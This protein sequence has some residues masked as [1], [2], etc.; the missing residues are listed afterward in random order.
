MVSMNFTKSTTRAQAALQFIPASVCSQ[1]DFKAER[2]N[3]VP[4]NIHS[5]EVGISQRQGTISNKELAERLAGSMMFREFQR[6]FEDATRMPLTLRAVESWQLAHAESRHQNGFCG[7]MSQSNRLCSGCLQTQQ[8]VCDGVN[9]LP[10][11]L[12]CSFGLNETAVGVKIG[13]EII[14]YLQTGQVLFKAPTHEQA[15]RALQKIREWGVNLDESEAFRRYQETPVIRRHEYQAKVRLLQF[16]A[17]QLG[18]LANWVV[19]QKKNGEMSQIANARQFI[20]THYQ[21]YLSLDTVARHVGMSKFYFC[22]IFK[23]TTG[24][25]FTHYVSCFRVEKAKELFLNP[26]YRVSE[27]AYEVGFQSLTHFN[28]VFKSIVGESPTEYRQHLPMA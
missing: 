22:K 1:S 25:N 4:A 2:L 27:I 24:V 16:F 9:G 19:L 23:K 18:T 10:C 5:T 28:R 3:F 17:D 8:R 6:A 21:E 13:G 7:L 14:A 12:T 11:T 20:E 26:N 15:R